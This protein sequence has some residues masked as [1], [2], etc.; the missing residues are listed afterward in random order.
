MELLG[1]VQVTIVCPGFVYS[2]IHQ[3]ALGNEKGF[4][5]KKEEF[6][7]AE[8]CAFI[9]IGKFYILSNFKDAI[10]DGV[11]EEVMTLKGKMGVYIKPFF[12]NLIDSFAMKQIQSVKRKE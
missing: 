11:A 9:M 8:E 4:E 3:N 1:Q 12:P 6:M 2:E 5:R 7:S 10:E